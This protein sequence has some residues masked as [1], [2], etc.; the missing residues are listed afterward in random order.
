MDQQLTSAQIREKF[1]T[2]F[3]GKGHAIVSSSSLIP[4]DDP[5]LLFVNAGMTQFKDLFLGLEKRDYQRATTSQKCMRVAGKHN[6]LENV[7]PSPRHHTFFEMLGNF[8][9]G[10]YFKE[11]AIAY[12]WEFLTDVLGLAKERL[13]VSIYEDDNEA[14]EYWCQHVPSERILRFGKDDNFWEMGDTGPCGPCSEIHYYWGDLDKQRATGVNVDDEYLEIW[15]L[16]FI[17]FDRDAQGV[18]TPLPKLSIDTGLGFERIVSVLQGQSNNYDTDLFTPIFE[19]TQALLGHSDEKRA[20]NYVAYRVIADH[21]RAITFMIGDGV[22]PGN[23]GRPYVLRL[24]LR[25][26]ARYGR[27]LGFTDSFLSS[28]AETVI[29]YMGEHYRELISRRQFILNVIQQEEERFLKTYEYGLALLDELVHKL[30]LSNKT[31]IPGQEAFKLHATYGFPIGLTM[32]IAAEEYAFTVDQAGFEQAMAEHHEI[33]GTGSF[34]EINSHILS[35]YARLLEDIKTQ[36]ITPRHDPYHDTTLETQV[37]AILQ[38]GQPVTQAGEGYEVELILAETPFY[39][40]SGGQISDTGLIQNEAL[41][42]GERWQMTVENTHRPVAGLVVHYGHI[43]QG[44]AKVHDT[45]KAIVDAERRLNIM[46]NHTATHLLHE[47]LRR[48]L[49]KHVAQAGSLVAPDRL[50]FDFSHPDALTQA[51]IN[52]VMAGVNQD[53]LA[54]QAVTDSQKSYQE[55]VETGAMALFG[56]KYGDVVRVV[57][58]DGGV[59]QELCGG[60]HVANT[61]H[62][63]SLLIT[64]ESSVAAGIRRIEALTGP[65]A[66]EQVQ[67]QLDILNRVASQLGVKPSSVEDRLA[68]LLN[69]NQNLDKEVKDLKRQLARTDFANHLNKVKDVQGISLLVAQVAVDDQPLLREM[70]DWFRDKLGSG[71]VVLGTVLNEKPNF[72]AMVTDDLAKQGLHA[73]KLVKAAAQVV[74]GSGGGRPTMAQAGGRDAAKLSEALAK[75]EILVEQLA[76]N[77]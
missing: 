73:G 24:I 22:M 8:S 50:R 32:D 36:G 62:I 55:A 39:V 77:N 3:E 19:R 15:N 45:V 64:S 49:G 34:K 63:G 56:E 72:I 7:G 75:V 23:E 43:T 52:T 54:N 20:T 47:H 76:I 38:D 66:Q 53:I 13:W 58:I 10:D 21:G 9:F 11:D 51:E 12:A 27:K 30:K 61:S 18:L 4:S 67:N 46:R 41:T 59:S 14:F 35:T 6:D 33:S 74:G 70:G 17:Q 71:V 57:S 25:R 26:A 31:E 40:E 37:L 28:I 2:F 48:T 29:D 65:T 60:T 1:L 68:A 42:S 69:R 44:T 16:V 5:T